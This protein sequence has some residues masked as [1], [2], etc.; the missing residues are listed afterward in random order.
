MGDANFNFKL[1]MKIG[2]TLSV[3]YCFP[4]YVTDES[5]VF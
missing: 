1:V 4:L 2:Q 3:H 5:F